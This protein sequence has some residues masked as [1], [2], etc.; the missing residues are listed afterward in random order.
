MSTLSEQILQRR[1]TEKVTRR[2]E[3]I[4]GQFCK[5][6]YFRD[7]GSFGE[8]YYIGITIYEGNV[9]YTAEDLTDDQVNQFFKKHFQDDP[10]F[11]ESTVFK[12]MFMCIGDDI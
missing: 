11:F 4:R 3:S 9:T 8:T 12:S 2:G 1:V 6:F 7:P 10:I 5:V